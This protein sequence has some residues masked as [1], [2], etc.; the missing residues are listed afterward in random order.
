MKK[1]LFV[2]PL[3][4]VQRC[5][6]LFLC[7]F[8]YKI[9]KKFNNNNNSFNLYIYIYKVLCEDFLKSQPHPQQ[10]KTMKSN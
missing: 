4:S 2:V 5:F 7:F 9:K 6:V 8:I 3:N 10:Y 1:L